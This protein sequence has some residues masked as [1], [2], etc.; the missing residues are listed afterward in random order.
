MHHPPP[1]ALRPGRA[2]SL[3]HP[4]SILRVAREG[5]RVHHRTHIG[6]LRRKANNSWMVFGETPGPEQGHVAEQ[7]NGTLFSPALCLSGQRRAKVTKS[8]KT[9]IDVGVSVRFR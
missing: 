1:S 6:I 9:S 5:L 4:H 7:T 2:R 8:P 3:S